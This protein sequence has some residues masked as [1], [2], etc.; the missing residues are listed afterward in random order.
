[1]LTDIN[2]ISS[3]QNV[4]KT[5]LFLAF[6]VV[7]FGCSSFPV[8]TVNTT[9]PAVCEGSMA[10][11]QDLKSQFEPIEDK[12]LLDRSLGNQDEGKLCQGKVYVSKPDSHAKIYRA[13]N[14]T[15]PGSRFGPWWVFNKPAGRISEYRENYEICYQWSPLDKLLSCTLK[16]GTKVVVGNGQSAKCSDYLTYPVSAKQQVYIIDASKFVENCTE[17]DGMLNWE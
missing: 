7:L 2:D 1:M 6:T 9:P 4:M 17:Y 14:S 16:P 11:L 8:T 10:L 3:K 15:N 12:Q 13:W 5:I